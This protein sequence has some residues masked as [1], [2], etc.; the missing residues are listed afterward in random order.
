M[1]AAFII[2]SILGCDDN[3]HNCEAVATLDRQWVS[4]SQCDQ[5]SERELS[6]YGNINFPMVVAVCQT[7]QSTALEDSTEDAPAVAE[8][9]QAQ[10]EETKPEPSISSRAI[11]LVSKVLPS[12]K[13]LE[14]A[15]E[16]PIHVV[17]DTYSWVARKIDF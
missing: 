12:R 13:K 10:A 8:A 2:M 7:E 15:I 3:G 1:K 5:A 17:T 6:S 4:I 16:K 9:E 14:N 11:D